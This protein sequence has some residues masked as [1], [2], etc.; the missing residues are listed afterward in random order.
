MGLGPQSLRS[1]SSRTRSKD[2]ATI[3]DGQEPA[4]EQ[5][6]EKRHALCPASLCQNNPHNVQGSEPERRRRTADIHTQGVPISV[7]PAAAPPHTS[8]TL[9]ILT[10]QCPIRQLSRALRME[11]GPDL[12]RPGCL[13]QNFSFLR[14]WFPLQKKEY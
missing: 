14:W 5:G 8:P 13:V 6:E 9:T 1:R 11:E 7:T 12:C 10:C 2:E 3:V 4:A